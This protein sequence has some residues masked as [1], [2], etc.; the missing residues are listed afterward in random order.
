[1]NIFMFEVINTIILGGLAYHLGKRKLIPMLQV[2]IAQERAYKASLMQEKQVLRQAI[3]DAFDRQQLQ[4]A[5]CLTLQE[6][7]EKWKQ[8]CSAVSKQNELESEQLAAQQHARQVRINEYRQ[9]QVVYKQIHDT[10]VH[11]VRTQ[12]ESYYAQEK[13]ARDYLNQVLYFLEKGQHGV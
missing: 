7:V 2:R 1:M 4:R 10:V 8:V 9:T 11:D 3:S 13:V 5:E 12:L 6:K